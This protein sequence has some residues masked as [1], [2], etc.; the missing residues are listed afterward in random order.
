MTLLILAIVTAVVSWIR[1]GLVERSMRRREP[2]PPI[3]VGALLVL[4]VIGISTVLAATAKHSWTSLG[5][6]ALIPIAALASCRSG[7]WS[8]AGAA[9]TTTASTRST[10]RSAVRR[11][12]SPSRSRWPLRWRW[13][14]CS[15]GEGG[16]RRNGAV[17]GRGRLAP[18][19][20]KVQTRQS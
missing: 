11:S 16:A 13:P 7:S 19:C 4:A 3:G 6:A 12:P 18:S 5:A 14:T 17:L 15:P 1:W 2:K 20:A 8:R 9:T 10:A